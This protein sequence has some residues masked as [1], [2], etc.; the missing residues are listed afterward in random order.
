MSNDPFRHH[1]NLRQKI[2][3]PLS[4]R[5]RSLDLSDMDRNMAE[6][7][8]G[9]GWRR[10]DDERDLSRRETLEGRLD[11][12]LWVFAYGSLMWDPGFVFSEVRRATLDG[13][14]RRFCLRSEFGRGT[15]D[16]PGLMAGLD[17]G[18]V[19]QGLAFKID[20]A[21]VED[22]SHFL[23]RREM[24]MHSYAPD[25]LTL[26][27]EQGQVEALCFL[28]NRQN[29][30]LLGSLSLEDTAKHIARAEGY[31]GPN[32]DYLENL[33][34]YFEWLKLDDPELFELRDLAWTYRE[35]LPAK[36]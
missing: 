25:F 1:P 9:P 30:L 3:E 33:A 28:V 8:L 5:F 23:W 6:R 34:N 4:S 16:C 18:G 21:L 12:D 27:T 20:G 24:V 29:P 26:E 22:E 35:E 17:E 15:P 13:Y 19:C 10:S 32:I 36:P 2:Q 11:M 7:G 14:H 31:L